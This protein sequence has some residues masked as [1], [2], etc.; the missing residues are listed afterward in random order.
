V[1]C[2]FKNHRRP[3][4]VEWVEAFAGKLHDIGASR[5]AM[6]SQVGYQRGAAQV[7]AHHGIDLFILREIG[8]DEATRL[9]DEVPDAPT[10]WLFEG[11]GG[12][13]VLGTGSVTDQPRRRAS[14]PPPPQELKGA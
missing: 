14:D 11:P 13:R 3:I 9:F 2:E 7:A 5:G 4:G 10:Y 8:H 6:F 12:M 1:A